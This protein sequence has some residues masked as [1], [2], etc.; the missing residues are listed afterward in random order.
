MEVLWHGLEMVKWSVQTRSRYCRTP[1]SRCQETAPEWWW[2]WLVSDYLM[3]DNMFVL[4]TPSTQSSMSSILSI[5]RVSTHKSLM[6]KIGAA[7]VMALQK[8]EHFWNANSLWTDADLWLQWCK[9]I[10][11]YKKLWPWCTNSVLK[12]RFHVIVERMV[13]EEH[14][15]WIILF[16]YSYSSH[17]LQH[18]HWHNIAAASASIGLFYQGLWAL[19]Y[20]CS[21]PKESGRQS[22][23]LTLPID[24]RHQTEYI[25]MSAP[26]MGYWD[27][28]KHLSKY[29]NL[30][31]Y[32]HHPQTLLCSIVCEVHSIY[33]HHYVDIISSC[34]RWEVPI[35]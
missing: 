33:H 35:N 13:W 18:R 29:W 2:H 27:I 20:H 4:S 26:M 17:I 19:S 32:Q 28:S 25:N 10:S 34:R 5:L 21:H 11:V 30:V 15:E 9:T 31:K 7:N 16:Y 1:G 24:P 23:W 12:Q 8:L 3:L 22:P 6:N 14:E